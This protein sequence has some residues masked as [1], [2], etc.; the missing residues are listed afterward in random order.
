MTSSADHEMVP[1]TPAATLV[2]FRDVAAGP[3]ELLMVERSGKMAF[4]AGAVVFPG[5]K[6]DPDDH[7]VAS[8][9]AFVNHWSGTDRDDAAARV[10]AIR[11]TIEE[12]GIAVGLAQHPDA[13]LLAL[14]RTQL[15]AQTP[16]STLLSQH[17]LSL[18]LTALHPFARWRPNF[19]ETRIFDAMF[20]L[21][22][23]PSDAPAPVVDNTE[24]VN[25]FWGSAASVLTAIAEARL[26]AIFPTVRNLERL[27]QFGSFEEAV[28]HA[29]QFPVR[30]I[31]PWI[32][33]RDGEQHLCIP[34]DHG[35]PLTSQSIGAALRG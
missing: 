27:A 34:D 15:C 28:V 24:N 31:T 11:E 30:M 26:R 6:V 3:P 5:G 22:R 35:Y 21:A 4:A 19:R 14:L 32:E 9:P 12:S 10:A 18:D 23:V 17:Q 13:A 2:L 16:F 20:Y 7:E 29:A 25:T 8:D 1:A 33:E